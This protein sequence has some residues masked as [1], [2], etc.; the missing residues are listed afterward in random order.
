M[1]TTASPEEALQGIASSKQARE[2]FQAFIVPAEKI[3]EAARKLRE[4]GYDY[5]LSISAV[6]LPKEKRI[7]LVYHF[8]RTD[9]PSDQV[10]LETYVPRDKPQI[11]TIT[12]LY[13]AALFQEREEYE[14]LGVYFKGHP[15]LRHLLLPPD[16][17][18]GIHPLRK[19]FHVHEEPIHSS[20]PSKP[21]WVLK[22]ELKPKTGQSQGQ[23]G[24]GAA[25]KQ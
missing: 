3:R 6:D 16:W 25:K 13:P 2:N 1:S 8:T 22:P 19:D 9:N 24:Q 5:L 14:M 15:D 7:K 17:P 10:A 18:P 12:D 23:Q 4:L 11:D 21:I 20:K